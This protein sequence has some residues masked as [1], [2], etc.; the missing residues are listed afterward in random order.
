MRR[1]NESFTMHSNS[2]KQISIT[3]QPISSSGASTFQLSFR[4]HS[5]EF[6]KTVFVRL[7]DFSRL[8]NYYLLLFDQ[9]R[10]EKYRIHRRCYFIVP[11]YI[12][13]MEIHSCRS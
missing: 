4:Y 3:I 13:V 6:T 9:Y 12:C 8:E 11:K 7:Y 5:E 10:E 1:D 2:H